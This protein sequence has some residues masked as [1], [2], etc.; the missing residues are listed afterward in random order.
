M[1]KNM[2]LNRIS[3]LL[4]TFLLL[5]MTLFFSTC[6]EIKA[7]CD[8]QFTAKMDWPITSEAIFTT[9]VENGRRIF[10]Y[11]W[12]DA[13]IINVCM[14]RTVNYSL[15]IDKREGVVFTVLPEARL[16]W[17]YSM[18]KPSK[19][20]LQGSGKFQ[21]FNFSGSTEAVLYEYGISLPYNDESTFGIFIPGFEI[22]FPTLGNYSDDYQY[23][24]DNF[25]TYITTEVDYHLAF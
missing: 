23:L 9:R 14:S 15:A 5:S 25:V 3:P 6:D 17:R 1:S 13:T 18:P 20:L 12:K 4:S 22:K 16:I 2:F 11:L 21:T 7:P 24:R 10:Q 19:Q 8:E